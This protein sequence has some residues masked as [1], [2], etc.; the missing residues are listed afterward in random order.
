MDALL[1]L[2]VAVVGVGVVGAGRPGRGWLQRFR[3]GTVVLAL[4]AVVLFVWL[5]GLWQ[6]G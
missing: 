5:G 2:M 6:L 4:G 3:A 1:W